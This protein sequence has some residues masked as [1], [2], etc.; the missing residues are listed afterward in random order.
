MALRIT[1]NWR[2]LSPVLAFG[3]LM[4]FAAGL[5]SWGTDPDSAPAGDLAGWWPMEGVA[6]NRLPDASGNGC[7]GALTN[8]SA[9]A[10]VP[11]WEGQAL[12][13]TPGA[14]VSF[15]ELPVTLGSNGFGASLWV[16]GTNFGAGGTLFGWEGADG[17]GWDIGI[18]GEARARLRWRDGAE[19]VALGGGV[20]AL[21]LDDGRW[22]SVVAAAD[23][24]AGCAS[25][26][27][28]T[29]PEASGALSNWTGGAGA[30]RM[31]PL[32]GA[33]GAALALDEVRLHRVPLRFGDDG[34]LYPIALSLEGV[35]SARPGDVLRDILN[36]TRPGNFGWLTWSG[37]PSVPT[38]VA[39]LTPPGD[40]EHYTNPD[41][42]ADTAIGFGDWIQGCPGVKNSGQVRD[43]L[44]GLIGREILVPVWDQVR[45]GGNNA[46]Y[47]AVGVARVRVISYQISK[48]N[49]IT[50]E[51]L[52]FASC[53]ELNRP[54]EVRIVEPAGG[55]RFDAPA[56]I[57]LRAWA[58]DADGWVL[59]VEY[60]AASGE[61]NWILGVAGPEDFAFEWPGVGAGD[62][63]LTALAF[64]D[65]GRSALSAP[66]AVSVRR[67]TRASILSPAP[68]AVFHAPAQID[69]AA[70]VQG[71]G[72]ARVEFHANGQKIGEAGEAPYQF[73]W[74]EVAPGVYRLT[75]VAVHAD[76]T[77]T[78]SEAVLIVVNDPP[79]AAF[80]S[81]TNGAVIEAGA[82][83]PLI[84]EA[85]DSDGT[86][87]GVAFFA[88][89]ASNLLSLGAAA[90][91]PFAVIWTNA[92]PGYYALM[93]MATDDRGGTNLAEPIA[94]TVADPWEALVE[95]TNFLVVADAPVLIPTN[96]SVLAVSFTNLAFDTAD[97]QAINDAL[98]IALVDTNGVPLV[99]AF[100]PGR[101]A[102]LNLTEGEAPAIAAGVLL[103]MT[104]GAGTVHIDISGLPQ[105][106]GARLVAR[107]VNEDADATT[108]VRIG[109]VSLVQTN[110]AFPTN[111]A[112]P[113]ISPGVLHPE[114]LDGLADITADLESVYHRTS[115]DE[116]SGTLF[117]DL[118]LQNSGDAPIAGKIVL[119]IDG[120]SD[121][122]VRV[123][124][125]DG[126][127]PD[128]KPAFDFSNLLPEDGL[129]PGASTAARPIAFHNPNRVR[130]SY[131]LTLLGAA[132][133]PP[134]FTSTPR[135][136][137]APGAEYRYDAIAQDPD[138]DALAF[139]LLAAPSGMTLTLG[140]EPST[141]RLVWTPGPDDLGNHRITLRVE[142]GRG[143]SATQSF[144]LSVH[145]DTP[146]RPPVFTSTPV[147]DANIGA[148]YAYSPKADDPDGDP[149]TLS[150]VS[151]PAGMTLTSSLE[152]A[153]SR[154]IWSPTG[155]QTGVHTITLRAEDGRGGTA[156]QTF[157]VA[158]GQSPGNH[159][160]AF[161]SEPATQFAI[162]A[163]RTACGDVDPAFLAYDLPPG[164]GTV[165]TVS[166]ALSGDGTL[167]GSADVVFVVDE[168]G[169]M[170]TEHA[171]LADMIPALDAR[172]EDIGITSNRFAMTAFTVNPRHVNTSG[173]MGYVSVFSPSNRKIGSVNCSWDGVSGHGMDALPADGAYTVVVTPRS[174]ADLPQSF[175]LPAS[176]GPEPEAV[177]PEGFDQTYSGTLAPGQTI[178][179][180]FRAPAGLPVF[181][182][183]RAS[184]TS[185]RASLVGP[186]NLVVIGG[187]AASGDYYK[188]TSLPVSG[189]YHL[190]LADVGSGGPY[191]FR[192][193][194]LSAAP[195]IG[196]GESA[197]THLR[198]G[199]AVAYRVEGTAGQRLLFHVESIAPHTYGEAWQLFGADEFS[200]GT[201]L[202]SSFMASLPAD[203]TYYLLLRNTSGSTA[204]DHTFRALVATTRTLPLTVGTLVHDT[205]AEPGQSVLYQFHGNAGQRLW[206]DGRSPVNYGSR[207]IV[208]LITPSGTVVPGLSGYSLWANGGPIVLPETG[209][210]A[211]HFD[212]R[213]ETG[214]YAFCLLD[215]AAA[216]PVAT[217]TDIEVAVGGPYQRRIFLVEGRAGQRM[218][219]DGLSSAYGEWSLWGPGGSRLGVQPLGWDFTA[220]L[221]SDGTYTL[222]IDNGSANPITYR[223]RATVTDPVPVT[224]SGFGTV[225]SGAIAAANEEHRYTLHAPAGLRV[226]F[227]GITADSSQLQAYLLAPNGSAAIG[228]TAANADRG[229]VVLP[230]S[231]AYTLVVTGAQPGNYA[232]RILDL[233]DAPLLTP[234]VETTGTLDPGLGA[235]AYR[236]QGAAGH[237]L[238]IDKLPGTST[239]GHWNL[240]GPDN[241][242]ID[243]EYGT[244]SLDTTLPCAEPCVLVIAGN[245][246]A[247]ISYDFRATFPEDAFIPAQ[248]DRTIAGSL[249]NPGDRHVYHFTAGA[250]ERIYFDGRVAASAAIKCYLYSPKGVSLLGVLSPSPSA[251]VGPM[252][253]PE[254]G[255]Y[256]LLVYGG[257]ATG[258]YAFRL[259][260]RAAARPVGEALAGDLF[261][262]P[263]ALVYRFEAKAGQALRLE[264]FFGTA[265]TAAWTSEH[266]L[267]LYSAFG[268]EDGYCALDLAM[269]SLAFRPEAAKNFILLSDNDH[270]FGYRP[271]LTTNVMLEGLRALNAPLN[272][273]VNAE[274]ADALGNRALGVDA[275]GNA[276][277]PDGAGGY[278]TSTNG[279][280]IGP[281]FEGHTS[282]DVKRTYVDLS[283]ASG[284][285]SWDLTQVS[286]GGPLMAQSLTRAFVDIKAE[287]ILRQLAV[288]DLR[289]SDATVGFENLTG[290]LYGM[291]P[292]R[293]AAFDVRL[294]APEDA[295]SFELLFVHPG[296]GRLLGSIPVS[297]SQRYRYGA[298]AVDPDGDPLAYALLE[299]PDGATI[300]PATGDIAW[301]PTAPGTYA[302]AIRTDD[303]QGASATQRFQLEVTAGTANQ[304]PAITSQPPT[305]ADVGRNYG[306]Q[307][308]AEDPDGHP[309]TWFLV[310]GPDGMA[311][312]SSFGDPRS[313]FISW[314]PSPDQTGAYPV[315]IRVIDGRG[316]EATQSFT[317][318]A[319]VEALNRNPVFDSFPQTTAL[320]NTQ[321]RYDIAVS[322]PDHDAITVTLALAPEG[323][324][325]SSSS[326]SSAFLLPSSIIWSPTGDQIGTHTIILRATDARGAVTLQ[327]FQ[328]TVG[329]A[330]HAPVILSVAPS[331]AV[332]DLPYEYR[333]RARDPDGDAISF[334]LDSPPPGDFDFDATTGILRFRPTTGEIGTHPIEITALDGHNGES[335][336]SYTLAVV[337][338]ASNDPP[339]ITSTPSTRVR[340]GDT[341]SYQPTV[342][343][344][345]GDPL[346]FQILQSPAGMTLSSSYSSSSPTF[347]WTPTSSQLGSHPV[348]LRFS[349]GRGAPAEQTFTIQVFSGD[350]NADPE[351]TSVPITAAIVRQPYSCPIL[352]SDPDGDPLSYILESA[353]AGMIVSSALISWTPTDDDLGSHEIILHVL[354]NLGGL[355][356]QSFTLTVRGANL[357][358]AITSTPP[359][360]AALDHL[361]QYKIQAQDPEGDP[362]TFQLLTAPSGMALSSSLGDPRSALVSWT[363]DSSQLGV[364]AIELLAQDPHGGITAQRFEIFVSPTAPNEMPTIGGDPPLGVNPGDLYSWTITASDPEE[365][366]VTFR[367][368]DAPEGMTIDPVTGE[369][370][371]Q[372]ALTTE[373]D[374]RV[375]IV[376]E[377]PDGGAA[378]LSFTIRVAPNDAPFF[379]SEPL[380]TAIGGTAYR[381]TLRAHDPDGDFLTFTILSGPQGMEIDSSLGDP[382]SAL[383]S[384]SSSPSQIGT[385][386][387]ITIEVSDGRGGTATQS[388]TL[389][390]VADADVP[391]VLL[392]A[393]SDLIKKGE[394]VSFFIH[395]S[396]N[397]GIQSLGLALDGTPVPIQFNGAKITF[398][399]PGLFDVVATAIDAAG[400]TGSASVQ[401]RVI[402]P[403]DSEGPFVDLPTAQF[404]TN[405]VIDVAT[406]VRGTVR[407]EALEYWRLEVAPMDLVSLDNVAA[408]DPDY[409]LLAS[410][411]ANLDNGP[412]GTLDPTVLANDSYV[413]RLI[414]RDVNGRTEAA[415]VILS[416]VGELKP[417][418]FTFAITD[419]NLPLAGIPIQITRVYDTLDASRSEDFGHGW[420]LQFRQGRVRESVPKSSLEAQ[421]VPAIFAANPFKTGARV[422]LTHP[423]GRRVGFTFLPTLQE[424]S[425]GAGAGLFGTTWQPRFVPDRGVLDTLEVDDATLSIDPDGSVY[426]YLFHLPYNPS[427]YRL[428]TRDGRTYRYSES[429]GLLDVTDRNGNALTFSDDAITHSSGDSITFSRDALGRITAIQTPDGKAI[430]Y[431][432]DPN[433]DLVGVTDR[434]DNTTTYIYKQTHP[435]YLDRIIDPLNR[436]TTR[437]EYDEEGR[438]TRVIDAEGNATEIDID[439]AALQ[440]TITDPLGHPRTYF[441][442]ER[443][444]VVR[445]LDALNGL[446]RRT[447]D[448]NNNLLSATDP[449]GHTRTWTYDARGNPLTESDG[450]GNTTRRTFNAQNLP[451]TQVDPM[452]NTT[453]NTYDAAGNRLFRKDGAGNTVSAQYDSRRLPMRLTDPEGNAFSLENDDAG[454]LVTLRDPANGAYEFTYD[455]MGNPVTLT[456]PLGRVSRLGY[457]AEGRVI[458]RTDPEGGITRTEYDAAGQK[459]AE[460]DPRGHRTEHRYDERGNLIEAIFPDDTPGN[461]ADNPR[462]KR[463][464]DDLGNTI[465][466]A[467]ENGRFTRHVRDALG[468]LI[469]TIH[470]D[471][472]DEDF[473]EEPDPAGLAD[474]PTERK[475]WDAAGRLSAEIDARGNRTE[476]EYDAANRMIL[477]RDALGHETTYRH[478][479]AGRQIAVTDPLGRVAQTLFDGAGRETAT[480]FADGTRESRAFDGRGNVVKRTDP[481]G[482]DTRFEYSFLNELTAVIDALGQRTAYER[483]AVGN[484]VREIDAN[485]HERKYEYDGNR[486]RTAMV[487]P[488][489]QRSE[490]IHDPA[491]NP[492]TNITFNGE[493]IAMAYDPRNRLTERRIPDGATH[494]F[495]YTPTGK[496][497]TFTAPRGTITWTYDERDRLKSRTEPD[498]RQ[499][500]YTYDAAGNALT[501]TTPSGTVTYSFDALN[502]LEAVVDTDGATTA[503]RYNPVGS[504]IETLFPNGVA[505]TRTFD[506]LNRLLYLEN[507][508]GDGSVITSHR[509]TLDANGNR[510]AVEEHAGR[511]LE[512]Q[513]D[514][515]DRLTQEKI[516]DPVTGNRT[517][518]YLY[519]PVGNRLS[520]T[521]VGQPGSGLTTYDYD[522]NDRLL[523]ESLA[524]TNIV[525]GWDDAG[526]LLSKTSD[527][528][529][530]TTNQ[531]NALDHLKSVTSPS[532]AVQFHYDADNIRV[533]KTVD[534]SE[535]RFLIDQNRPFQEVLEEYLPGGTLTARY[536]HGL[537]LISQTRGGSRNYYHVDGLGN[538]RALSNAL[539]NVTDTY[540][541]EAFGTLIARSG[542]EIN[543]FLYIGEQRDLETGFTYLRARHMD[544]AIGRFLSRDPYD[545]NPI[546]PLS[547]HDFLYVDANPIMWVDPSGFVKIPPPTG[548]PNTW[549]NEYLTLTAD[550]FISL[551]LKASVRTVFPGEALGIEVRA[552]LAMSG[553]IG[554]TC[555]KLLTNLEYRK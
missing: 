353:P 34:H 220:V 181:Y 31:G 414:A 207:Q 88:A 395:A 338:D 140:P 480:I 506:P 525:Y 379:V 12:R 20:R 258:D 435:H 250:G 396:D 17:R 197:A 537:D 72:I 167:G 7:D 488:R 144:T 336:Q 71:D 428:T 355:A 369:L 233:S 152:P 276:Y 271:Y 62:Y 107:L 32:A 451:L 453:V 552:L 218:D 432:Y 234:G 507:R 65:G 127:T 123:L 510:M 408:H 5:D 202:A 549:G 74:T 364:Q 431:A 98:E 243:S 420:R 232:V 492:I 169:S 313:A 162:A 539:K 302:F 156:T 300:D 415:A 490:T 191:S 412:L 158:V 29:W 94:I 316:G 538:T 171:W 365:G 543:S 454:N 448:D 134:A 91:P 257:D 360:T 173:L 199:E 78:E 150:L 496:R 534:G 23:A 459:T 297:M 26:Y 462:I 547:L 378:I 437:T 405:G 149:V 108:A 117:A 270:F 361:Y 228:A 410:G 312:H 260:T 337:A 96:P 475:E 555:R 184:P 377:D 235:V 92:A 53:G 402:D 533:S 264:P 273:V 304:N 501:V 491:G 251:D 69:I 83:I 540:A 368:Q 245:T 466:V 371:W 532:S 394:T 280:F 423:D 227:D 427:V 239:V 550:K 553:K 521:V 542:T 100:A 128:G 145:S 48:E 60:R 287:E 460:I 252:T 210:Y 51:F 105:G 222:A 400:L 321:Y 545:G 262:P 76:G 254:S 129:G 320:P 36:G 15:A 309:L 444:N 120:I 310:E 323:M 219:L 472:T 118:A 290:P 116:T 465:A 341:W 452:G 347:I 2:A 54:P 217:G 119:V 509:Y 331:Q 424:T 344:P 201:G 203:G 307:L 447:F 113:S 130:F 49:R 155:H 486:R 497:E 244:V 196:T 511:F 350:P 99:P 406:A 223:F 384:W 133:H 332:A 179:N 295:R 131:R 122:S 168:T 157:C 230:Q 516:T 436:P 153:A 249:A 216:E 189:T 456:D 221:P 359:T 372:T 393:S 357:P 418:R 148:E 27:V 73:R 41:D 166:L 503:Y 433:G 58:A 441:Y 362:I 39:S 237:R 417:G 9:D 411:T 522:D 84:V 356:T 403:E 440:E 24:A 330:N 434:A 177:A 42:P 489:G 544:S 132:N 79:R 1:S 354:D 281:I 482:R 192:L 212:D 333:L 277:L 45:G 238:F 161:V 261:A 513:Y 185:A 455:A 342:H 505:E 463:R 183:G 386:H 524:G 327:P 407:D 242:Q 526:R 14:R 493:A 382:S 80:V 515:L 170:F 470:P 255:T 282:D 450:L 19:E 285:G 214:D 206:Y 541:Y 263:D 40:S 349:D 256:A 467:D 425:E 419:L 389:A 231:G 398:P 458:A 536:T 363:P 37:S 286:Q 111:A 93:A 474:N 477:R 528:Q 115:F 11:G 502:R 531:W 81:P 194:D 554:D 213:M 269:N 275:D 87:A 121:P 142:D 381:Y 343:D 82:G 430:Q 367:L 106:T 438:I 370:R 303:G 504:L 387:P 112:P 205:V 535:T 283:W 443:G 174:D 274:F 449:L 30:L 445:E 104:N 67:V 176:L 523:T 266:A 75:V 390:V 124:G 520:R 413:L 186:G 18:D 291:T 52:G 180:T 160:P 380:A 33:G 294:T 110:L 305:L 391:R 89:D 483:D 163:A 46:A 209:T 165:A 215:E 10:I 346:S 172:L 298:R 50:V 102:A 318:E 225:Y 226:Y 352:A 164:T 479:A 546:I 334:R 259:H 429:D 442:D 485:G 376:A 315:T 373:G 301:V 288:V 306:Y 85:A 500:G 16:A 63:S 141:S 68:G 514:A 146:N 401:I 137:T 200:A 481:A 154:L 38:L 188:M 187:H 28:D 125:A 374:H 409:R 324:I 340:F 4:V 147:V 278:T 314:S 317:L 385:S 182:D 530:P 279:V 392:S 289:C 476:F 195:P 139:Q 66:V 248:T 308:R 464:H 13:L 293:T 494:G 95:E 97:P 416:V 421:G 284:G 44:D 397:A 211:I 43:A 64:D 6:T 311:L 296:T 267:D 236:V 457:D 328:L 247:A 159:A 512:Y 487:L 224:A 240:Y 143:A 551:F 292:G 422:T 70:D 198:A 439:M 319:A 135:S 469:A 190:I 339:V 473:A 25:L 35:I 329:S 484:L 299:G 241:K 358:P 138:G 335:I 103:D 548:R 468:R 426:H 404:P 351:I 446:T 345:N 461:L 272:S 61:S 86:V 527:G 109:P 229:P 348:T 56:D 322:D 3:V 268:Q 208:S 8:F 508:K 326:A 265:Q 366:E 114:A 22:H 478:D 529:N 178:T 57:R 518:D 55:A 325:L 59:R 517:A 175:R 499:I 101:D 399:N 253:L 21:R 126:L 90:A 246:A 471:G 375:T 193:H 495:T 388:F 383:L 519:D 204:Y 498:G 136:T 47:R 77:I 151:G